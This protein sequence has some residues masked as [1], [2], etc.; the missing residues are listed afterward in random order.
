MPLERRPGGDDEI[1]ITGQDTGQGETE[2]R[3][4]TDPLPGSSGEA[5]VPY[6]QVYYEYLDAANEAIERSYIPSGLKDV[7]REYFTRL[8]P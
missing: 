7:V 3:E 1:T 6:Y 4:R 8:E 2:V 5:L